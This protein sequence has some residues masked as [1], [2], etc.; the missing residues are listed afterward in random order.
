M[1]ADR[2]CYC[3]F[4]LRPLSY[5]TDNFSCCLFDDRRPV[6]LHYRKCA[7]RV[8]LARLNLWSVPHCA[9]AVLPVVH[10]PQRTLSIWQVTGRT[11]PYIYGLNAVSCGS[12]GGR[13]M[14]E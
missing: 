5:V 12:V 1:M 11:R 14:Q 4:F 2:L 7:H 10:I 3:G 8:P 13:L 9:S 6:V